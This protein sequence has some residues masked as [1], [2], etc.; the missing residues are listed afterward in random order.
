LTP[1]LADRTSTYRNGF[2]V[3]PKRSAIVTPE[4]VERLAEDER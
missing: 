3:L 2:P 1:A 4:L